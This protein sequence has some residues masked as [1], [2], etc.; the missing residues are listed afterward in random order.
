[1]H[2]KQAMQPVMAQPRAQA[3]SSSSF[4]ATKLRSSSNT[5]SV[6][7]KSAASQVETVTSRVPE[8]LGW[9]TPTIVC[10]DSHS[11]SSPRRRPSSGGSTPP[12]TSCCT[13]YSPL[14]GTSGNAEQPARSTGGKGRRFEKSGASNDMVHENV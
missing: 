2:P 11:R 1:M 12:N 5:A 8:H 10:A 7:S 9:T 3:C 4:P 14:V 13:V 6:V